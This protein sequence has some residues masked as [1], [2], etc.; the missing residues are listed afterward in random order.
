MATTQGISS[1]IIF[2][3]TFAFSSN[4]QENITGTGH[5]SVLFEYKPWATSRRRV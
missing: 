3:I 2:N 4:V 1:Q 5:S